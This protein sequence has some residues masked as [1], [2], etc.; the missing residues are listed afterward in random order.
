[1][2]LWFPLYKPGNILYEA[3]Y[4]QN[5]SLIRASNIKGN[6]SCDG[7]YSTFGVLGVLCRWVSMG[8]TDRFL[9]L[10]SG[11]WLLMYLLCLVWMLGGGLSLRVLVVAPTYCIC[12][13]IDQVC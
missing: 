8:C 9:M 12:D 5:R 4:I 2:C 1:M 3:G 11:K 6:Y 7:L 13:K 10:W